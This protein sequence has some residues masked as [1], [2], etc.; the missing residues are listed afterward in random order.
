MSHMDMRLHCW[1]WKKLHMPHSLAV[2]AS[3]GKKNTLL[4]KN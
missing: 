1:H 3:G 2:A 4:N